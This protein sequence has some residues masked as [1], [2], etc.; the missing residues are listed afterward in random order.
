VRLGLKDL[1][2]C[3]WHPQEWVNSCGWR[4]RSASWPRIDFVSERLGG[5]AL[6]GKYTEGAWRSADATV[7]AS[8]WD[9]I[10][11][12]RNVLDTADPDSAWAVP[13]SVLAYVIDT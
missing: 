4:P 5:V 9:G 10:L 6:E 13:A 8:A 2:S 1:H 7:N 3:G 12:T 11:L